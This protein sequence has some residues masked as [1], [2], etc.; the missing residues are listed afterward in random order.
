ML[1]KESRLIS[2]MAF[3]ACSFLFKFHTCG[4][5]ENSLKTLN[6]ASYTGILYTENNF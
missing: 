2:H 3:G 1:L 6:I 4:Y 5:F